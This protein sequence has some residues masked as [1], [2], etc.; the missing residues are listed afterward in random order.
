[1][2]YESQIAA[3]RQ[4]LCITHLAPV[5]AAAAAH[6]VVSKEV[7]DDRTHTDIQLLDPKQRVTELARMLGGQSDASR[8]HAEEL[9]RPHS[10]P[11][12]NR[13]TKAKVT[14]VA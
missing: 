13:G 14:R 11:L 9:L 8:K 2:E 4:V 3:Q 12:E 7:K 1:M 6:Y 10:S 5:A